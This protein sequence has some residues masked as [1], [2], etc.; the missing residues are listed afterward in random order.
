V[1]AACFHCAEALPPAPARLSIDGASAVLLRRL[2]GCR[3]MDPRRAAG[4]LLRAAHGTAAR[5]F[6]EDADLAV[7][8]R[9]DVLAE[10]ARPIAGGRELTCS[11]T[12]CAARPAPG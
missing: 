10:H 9:E 4:R 2:R 8:D 3:A 5:V 11:P 1:P 7:W 12:A 6:D